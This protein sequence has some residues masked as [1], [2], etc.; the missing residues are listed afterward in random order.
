MK[1][2]QRGWKTGALALLASATALVGLGGVAGAAGLEH[3]PPP[4]AVV[5]STA[6]GPYGRV[7]V[8]GA[9]VTL[10]AFSGDAFPFSPSAPFQLPCT[11]LNTTLTGVPCTTPWPPLLATGPLV[12]RHGVRQAGLGTVTRNG[13]DQVTY[14]GHPLYTFVKDT[15]PGQ[16]NGEN[17]AAFKGLFWLVSPGGRPD[18]GRATVDTYV[19]PNGI[20]LTAPTAG[21]AQ[22][23]LYLLTYDPRRTST[24]TG[25]CTAIWPPLLT[26]ARPVAGTGAERR[27]LGTVRRSDGTRQVTYRGQPLYLFAFDLGAGA[28]PGLTTGEGFLDNMAHGAW[29]NV[30]PNGRADP[31]PAVVGSET[32]PA[33]Q[34]LSVTSA[35]THAGVTLYSFSADSSTAS[36]CSGACARFWPPVLTSTPPQ[37]TGG[38][39][40]SELGVIPRA[41]GTFQVT[42]YDHP[43]YYFSQDLTPGTS[44]NEITAFGGTFNIVGVAG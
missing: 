33:G 29:Y 40:Q 24:C 35:F 18:A 43:L 39:D 41:D 37:A 34:I 14:Y 8:T 22:R 15:A 36:K 23:S 5:V 20:V 3:H 2:W 1:L 44:G 7:L 31:G 4:G 25:P 32:V 38:V 30:W 13:V 42:Y 26:T 27:L 9:G 21:G 16:E 11:A 28:P 12:G 17:V 10:Y 19:S 6:H